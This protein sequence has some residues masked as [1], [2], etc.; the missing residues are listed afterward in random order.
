[1]WIAATVAL[2]VALA[3]CSIACFRGRLIDRL[4]GLQLAGA[5]TTLVFITLAVAARRPL[6]LDVALVVALTVFV[7]GLVYARFAER[8]L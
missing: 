6:Y 2:S 5:I 4:I 7:G 8:W 3:A 1:M